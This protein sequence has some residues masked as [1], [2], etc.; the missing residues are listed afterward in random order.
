MAASIDAQTT[1]NQYSAACTLQDLPV[2]RVRNLQ[3][4]NAAVY[5][6]VQKE[7]APGDRRWDPEFYSLPVTGPF[8]AQAVTGIA[9]RSAVAGTP[10]V[11]SA[12]I[13]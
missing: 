7:Y 10:A 8:A 9:F 2:G 6:K 11:V 13:A 12:L 4:S 5:V 3:I 1:S